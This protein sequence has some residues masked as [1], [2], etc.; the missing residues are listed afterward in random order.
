MISNEAPGM[1]AIRFNAQGPS[2]SVVTACSSGADA[3]GISLEM[4]RRGAVDAVIC[5]GTEAPITGTSV[6]GFCA[7]QAVSTRN[8]EPDRASRPFDKD[9]DGFVIAEGSGVIIIEELEH[10]KARGAQIYCELVGYGATC[11][12]YHIT[13]PHPDA[14][15]GIRAMRLA[16]EDSG[17]G[18]D[19]IDYINAH[20]TSTPLNDPTETRAIK[21]LFGDHAYKMKVSSTKSMHGHLLGGAGGIEAVICSLAMKHQFAPPTRNLD[22]PDPEC[23][24]DYVPHKGVPAEI[25]AAL[26]NS[27]GFG[28]HNGVLCFKRYE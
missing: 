8:D 2:Y 26:S 16:V 6:G 15:G 7:L 25:R 19:E 13:A 22:N 4:I 24:L 9:R 20:G 3:I 27:L 1:I 28:G 12:A 21:A 11:D 14:T 10:A 18:L 17:L 5:G 23:D